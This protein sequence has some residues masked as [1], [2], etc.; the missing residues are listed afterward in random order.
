MLAL[1]RFD[2]NWLVRRACRTLD[3]SREKLA[4][5]PGVRLM[6]AGLVK[7]IANSGNKNFAA[8]PVKSFGSRLSDGARVDVPARRSNG[9]QLSRPAPMHRTGSGVDQATSAN[10]VALP[11]TR[12]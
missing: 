3:L 12:V 10:V 6:T 8:P 9:H 11:L 5:D 4:P 2:P 7:R 1:T